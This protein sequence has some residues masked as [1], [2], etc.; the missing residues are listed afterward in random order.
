VS[1]TL[2]GNI[3]RFREARDMTQEELALAVGRKSKTAVCNWERG[4]TSPPS[5]LVPTIAEKLGVTVAD[6]YAVGE[7]A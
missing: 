2:G 3:R 4:E 7:A 1:N 6:L 5:D